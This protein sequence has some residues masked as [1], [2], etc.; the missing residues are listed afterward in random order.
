MRLASENLV[1]SID[2]PDGASYQITY[3]GTPG[4]SGDVTTGRIA[5]VKLPTGGTITYSYSGANNGITCADGS[6]ATLTRATPDGTWTYAHTEPASPAPWTT[7][8]TDP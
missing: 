8:V 4:F 1:S 2:L 3:E 6:A 7:T 5:S